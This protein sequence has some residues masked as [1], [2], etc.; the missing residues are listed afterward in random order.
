MS[1]LIMAFFKPNPPL[2]NPHKVL[3]HALKTL[4]EEHPHFFDDERE[5]SVELDTF[6]SS[7]SPTEWAEPFNDYE[8]LEIIFWVK[9]TVMYSGDWSEVAKFGKK[10]A[11]AFGAKDI[12][13]VGDWMIQEIPFNQ[14]QA[15]QKAIATRSVDN[16][17]TDEGVTESGEDELFIHLTID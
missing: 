17:Y 11:K 4:P 6:S 9:S 14:P 5:R 15:L 13:F 10:V 3:Q 12:W 1:E 2:D 8:Y 7:L 16:F